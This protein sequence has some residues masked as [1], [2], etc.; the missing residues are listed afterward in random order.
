MI[1][2]EL[3]GEII[4]TFY[5]VYNVLGYGFLEKIYHKALLIELR[6]ARLKVETKKLTN[7]FYDGEIIGEFETDLIVEE[8]VIIEIKAKECLVEAHEAQLINYLRA[9]EIESVYY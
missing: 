5:K 8:K 9:I 3:T 7:V 6:K 1:E 4:K 2:E